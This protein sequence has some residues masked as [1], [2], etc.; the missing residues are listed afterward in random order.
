MGPRQ[1]LYIPTLRGF[2]FFFNFLTF[3]LF[4]YFAFFRA[5]PT[6]HGDSQAK[7]AN[8]SYSCWP[9]TQPQQRRVFFCFVLFF[10]LLSIQLKKFIL[11]FRNYQPIKHNYRVASGE[12]Y[13][14]VLKRYQIKEFSSLSCCPRY[15]ITEEKNR[16]REKTNGQGPSG[17]WII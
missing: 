1:A 4:I 13:V 9:M 10:L 8:W 12:T 14:A 3:Y 17:P 11:P 2:V 7:G 6:A 15:F 16:G 5:A